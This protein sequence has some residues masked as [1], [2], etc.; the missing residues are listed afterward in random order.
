MRDLI[1]SVALVCFLLF[2]P[3]SAFT[4]DIISANAFITPHTGTLMNGLGI[5]VGGDPCNRIH[6]EEYRVPVLPGQR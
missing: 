4:Q 5:F 2:A 1:I 6:I 3:T